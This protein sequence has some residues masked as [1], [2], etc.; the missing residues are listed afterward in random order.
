MD[1][2]D[3]LNGNC[4]GLRIC[5]LAGTTY[6]DIV[7]DRFKEATI[8]TPDSNI[9][10][11][12]SFVQS[13]NNPSSG[14][15]VIA[16]GPFEVAESVVRKN[17]PSFQQDYE[18]KLSSKTFSHEPLALVTREDDPFWSDMVQW[19]L[20]A[21]LAD[22]ERTAPLTPSTPYFGPQFTSFF[23]NVIN[24]VGNYRDLYERHLSA[25][26]PRTEMNKINDGKSTGLIFSFPFGS[27][28]THGP[29]PVDGGTLKETRERGHLR[30]GITRLPGFAEFDYSTGE[31]KGFDVDFCKAI[32][33]AIFNGVSSTVV[34][35]VI[36]ATERFKAL[37]NGDVDVL[38]RITT[39]N[40]ERDVA[41]TTAGG[42]G[43][44]FSQINFY[45]GFTVGGQPQ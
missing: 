13:R 40:L 14:C 3:N 5:V 35:T 38:S 10:S 8:N 43:F 34:Y 12:E 1:C 42:D 44:D 33:A 25:I 45:D 37:A 20:Q 26:L 27:P 41:E 36:P 18:Y 24:A 17:T 11:Y 19:V 29:G 9:K 2:I 31:W 4:T 28:S 30:C 21:L 16:G 32:S 23:Q 7:K 15:N 6:V 22:E 39:W